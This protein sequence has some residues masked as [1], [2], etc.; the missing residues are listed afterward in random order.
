MVDN[1]ALREDPAG[2]R[3]PDKAASQGKIDGV[4]AL[5]MALDRAIRQNVGTSVYETRGLTVI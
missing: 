5:L 4:V 3:K 1:L 2:N